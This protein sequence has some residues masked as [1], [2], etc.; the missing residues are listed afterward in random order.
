MD[1]ERVSIVSNQRSLSTLTVLISGKSW[2][3][4]L[5]TEAGKTVRVPSSG[6]FNPNLRIGDLVVVARG[7]FVGETK[8]YDAKCHGVY[9]DFMTVQYEGG[10]DGQ[11]I[12]ARLKDEQ[13]RT[14]APTMHDFT[15]ARRYQLT[16]RSG[17]PLS[18][19]QTPSS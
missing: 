8:W 11:A 2:N 1:G 14:I 17:F 5:N 10:G 6:C 15:R 16:D 9:G 13:T 19:R 12:L 3:E 18:T 7:L 4:L